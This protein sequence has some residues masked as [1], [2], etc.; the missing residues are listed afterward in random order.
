MAH[1]LFV[2]PYYPPEK[3][4]A[5]VRISENAKRLVKRGHQVTI[6]TTVPNYPTGKVPKEY[7]RGI[8]QHEMIEGVRIIRV[9]T[10]ITEHKGFLRRILAQLS[11]GCLAPLIGSRAVGNPDV[12][13][14]QSPPLFDAIAGRLLSRIKRCPFI[15]MV[16]DLWPESGIQLNAI[17]SRLLIRI[18]KWLEWSTYQRASLVWALSQGIQTILIQRGLSPEHVFLLTNGADTTKFCP[19]QKVYARAELGWDNKFTILYAGTHGV[20]HGLTTVLD[21]AEQMQ[22]RTEMHFLF[23]GDGSEKAG[24]MKQA[25]SRK[26]RNVS[27]LDALPY[28]HMPLALAAA[29]ICLV[30]MRKVPLF[31]GRLPLKMFEVMASGRPILLGVDGEA[32]QLAEQEAGAALYIEPEN[33]EELKAAIIYLQEHPEEAEAMGQRGRAYVEA[34]FDRDQLAAELDARIAAL[35]EK[36]RKNVMLGATSRTNIPLMS[37][38]IL[39]PKTAAPHSLPATPVLVSDKVE[40]NQQ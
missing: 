26:I 29:D 11:F 18:A 13:I 21:A 39:L 27:F 25:R 5:Q 19:L 31:E 12:I 20:S 1:I 4:A 30:L 15:F 8:L 28:D 16:S 22:D 10:Y 37:P 38:S 6:L 40:D 17:R 32:R 35:L 9:W 2:T 34:R 14:V 33:E 24:L 7:R 3:G 23:V 36:E